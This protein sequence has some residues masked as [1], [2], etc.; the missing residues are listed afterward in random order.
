MSLDHP[1]VQDLSLHRDY[2]DQFR[3]VIR[4]KLERHH[5]LEWAVFEQLHCIQ[6]LSSTISH[7]DWRTLLT[8]EEPTYPEL[9]WEFYTTFQYRPKAAR[10]SYTVTFRL[11]GRPRELTIDGVAYAMGIEYHPFS[12]HEVEVPNPN[13]WN[14]DEFYRRIARR[15]YGCDCFDAGR[16]TVRTLK[17]QWH[18]LNLL[19]TRS[20]VPN[21][22]GSHKIPKRVLY[23]MYSMGYPDHMLHLGSFVATTFSRCHGKP[24]YLF[25]GPVITRLARHFDISFDG[26]TNSNVRG[27]STPLSRDVLHNALLL[28]TDGTRSWVD[29]LSMPPEEDADLDEDEEDVDYT[30]EEG[31]DDDDGGGGGAMDADEPE[32]PLSP[33]GDLRPRRRSE[34]GESSSGPSRASMASGPSMDFFT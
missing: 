9:V 25:C 30:A 28:A 8:I 5:H 19:I 33:P 17:P 10:D 26:L 23:A 11:G 6:E 34:R 24:N 14:M 1:F 22:T 16:T 27:G 13:D 20:I 4:G 29:G 15:T 2:A 7:R 32:T 31:D 18:I 12:R 3:K 21:V